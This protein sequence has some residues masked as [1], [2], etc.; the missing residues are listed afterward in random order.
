MK[1]LF[2]LVFP[3]KSVKSIQRCDGFSSFGLAARPHRLT[4]PK[5]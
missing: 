3:A 4:I 2:L 1:D 5:A